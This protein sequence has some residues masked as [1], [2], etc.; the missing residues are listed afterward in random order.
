MNDV[1]QSDV[2]VAGNEIVTLD[3]PAR[4]EKFT[5][6]AYCIVEEY[7]SLFILC[8]IFIEYTVPTNEKVNKKQKKF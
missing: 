6:K 7:F 1:W 8:Q 3:G 5:Q 2:D 4:L